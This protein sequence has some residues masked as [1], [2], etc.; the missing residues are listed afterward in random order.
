M[1][2]S[3]TPTANQLLKSVFLS[4]A[5]MS[6]SRSLLLMITRL[7]SPYLVI[8]CKHHYFFQHAGGVRITLRNK[9]AITHPPT[10]SLQF[11]PAHA[12]TYEHTCALYSLFCVPPLQH[13]CTSFEFYT[14]PT[15]TA[16]K[17]IPYFTHTYSH[18]GW[19]KQ[20]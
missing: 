15:Q 17:C 18:L 7:Y 20:P 19:Y 10:A 5:G 4:L 12:Q 13:S 11:K 8:Q 16:V 3:I 9:Q 14:T 1:F 2:G 6:T